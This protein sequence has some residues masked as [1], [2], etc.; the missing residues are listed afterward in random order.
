MNLSYQDKKVL[1]GLLAFY[2]VG[3]LVSWVTDAYQI[4]GPPLE[5]GIDALTSVGGVAVLYY[6]YQVIQNYGESAMSRYLTVIS[7]GLGFFA[8]ALPFHIYMHMYHPRMVNY[9]I[10]QHISTAWSF[11]IMAYGFFLLTRGGKQ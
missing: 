4:I 2:I 1:G 9:F 7:V 3:V 6:L 5:Y 10:F 11:V 8:L